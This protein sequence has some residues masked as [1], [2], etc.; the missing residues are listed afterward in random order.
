MASKKA[1]ELLETTLENNEEAAS[2]ME[3]LTATK[4]SRLDA[5]KTHAIVQ[6]GVMGQAAENLLKARL[7]KA[8]A[9]GTRTPKD[10]LINITMDSRE[11]V[12]CFMTET[13]DSALFDGATLP[14][15]KF[16]YN[17][18]IN[19]KAKNFGV[20][21][22]AYNATTD[23]LVFIG[24]RA[25]TFAGVSATI[26]AKAYNTANGKVSADMLALATSLGYV[27]NDK[28]REI[29]AAY[30]KGFGKFLRSGIA[31]IEAIREARLTAMETIVTAMEAEASA[32]LEISSDDSAF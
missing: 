28:T 31:G 14:V 13:A 25:E 19:G 5:W 17:A 27:G 24:A 7:Q 23:S 22:F 18:E 3:E 1:L 4:E 20:V 10:K 30:I 32:T 9:K 15:Y 11:N 26:N 2:A 12:R 6:D 16:G 8:T 21:K 29:C